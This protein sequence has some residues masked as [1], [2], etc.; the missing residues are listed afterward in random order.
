MREQLCD[1]RKGGI[2]KRYGEAE[3]IARRDRDMGRLKWE[4]KWPHQ[5]IQTKVLHPFA[6]KILNK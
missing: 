5:Q 4:T 3:G 2:C 6:M 1:R